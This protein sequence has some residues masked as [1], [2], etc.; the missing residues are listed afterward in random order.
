MI[1][2]HS[3]QLRNCLP[4]SDALW[5]RSIIIIKSSSHKRLRAYVSASYVQQFNSDILYVDS[6]GQDKDEFIRYCVFL[7]YKHVIEICLPLT[8]EYTLYCFLSYL[9][10]VRTI[11]QLLHASSVNKTFLFFYSFVELGLYSPESPWTGLWGPYHLVIFTWELKV[12]TGKLLPMLHW[13][14]PRSKYFITLVRTS[15]QYYESY[16]FCFFFVCGFSLLSVI[17]ILDIDWWVNDGYIN[18]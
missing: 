7:Q 12:Q 14:H 17:S 3:L 6:P 9:Y 1:C 13:L 8:L 18:L 15:W 11:L 4:R 16:V 2:V 5:C 10:S